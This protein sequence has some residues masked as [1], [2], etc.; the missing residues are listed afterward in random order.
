MTKTS[1]KLLCLLLSLVLILSVF[2]VVP[3]SFSATDI[4]DTLTAADFT[5]IKAEY[6]D[7]SN[8]KKTSDAKYAGNSAKDSSGNIQLRSK[9]SNSGI[10]STIS[11]GTV[12]SVTITVASGSNT[13]DIY[14]S[15]TAYTAASDLYGSKQGTKIGSLSATGTVTF[16]GS[17]AYVGI[18]S[19]SGAIYLNAVEIVWSG[20]TVEPP[21]EPPT[22]PPTEPPT[23][24]PTEAPTQASTQPV[25]PSG[26]VTD[27]LN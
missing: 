7:F 9:N 3:V 19:N 16:T 18:R 2:T 12:K 27:T 25:T 13:I 8:V 21:T 17:Y 5:A 15:N 20:G 26:S 14:G 24:P 11:G 4:S 1:K 6:T 23:D 10:V 22:D